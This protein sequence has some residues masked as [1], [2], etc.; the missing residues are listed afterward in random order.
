M[1][2]LSLCTSIDHPSERLP[3]TEIRL[4]RDARGVPVVQQG[5][6]DTDHREGFRFMHVILSKLNRYFGVRDDH[7]G[8]AS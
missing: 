2:T 4:V 5:A 1:L 7:P 8:W 6:I 3:S